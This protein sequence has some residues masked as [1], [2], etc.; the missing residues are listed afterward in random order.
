VKMEYLKEVDFFVR[1]GSFI[2]FLGFQKREEQE[3]KIKIDKNEK[4]I[5]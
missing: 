1:G 5:F 3:E 2:Y 4:I